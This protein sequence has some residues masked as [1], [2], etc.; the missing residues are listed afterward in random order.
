M[1]DKEEK[2]VSIEKI[3]QLLGITPREP[4]MSALKY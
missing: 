4:I 2:E 3:R 1:N